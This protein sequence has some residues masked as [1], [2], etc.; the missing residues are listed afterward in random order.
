[1]TNWIQKCILLIILYCIKCLNF[2]YYIF[3][4]VQSFEGNIELE[5]FESL[6]VFTI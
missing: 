5:D 3:Q 4:L 1:M 2:L 6:Q